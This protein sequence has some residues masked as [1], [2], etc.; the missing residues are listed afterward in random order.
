MEAKSDYSKKLGISLAGAVGAGLLASACCTI[1]LLLVL[2][3]VG[4]AWMST[5]KALE[6][7]RPFFIFAAAGLL[8]YAYRKIE[9]DSGP[10]VCEPGSA[11]ADPRTKKRNKMIFWI[12]AGVTLLFAVSPAL[13]GLLAS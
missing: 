13:I 12:A 3:G 5:L 10:E 6:P 8:Y 7:L 1:P 4:G 9:N 2:A 11:C